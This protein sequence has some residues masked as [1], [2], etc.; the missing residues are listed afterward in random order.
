MTNGGRHVSRRK[1]RK[2]QCWVENVEEEKGS[3]GS[4]LLGMRF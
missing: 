2:V 4:R 1:G 3:A